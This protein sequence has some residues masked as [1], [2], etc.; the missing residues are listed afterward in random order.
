MC[1]SESRSGSLW[2][3]PRGKIKRSG[4]YW[5]MQVHL[6]NDF[7]VMNVIRLLGYGDEV[8]SAHAGTHQQEPRGFVRLALEVYPLKRRN[9]RHFFVPIKERTLP[10]TVIMIQSSEDWR[11]SFIVSGLPYY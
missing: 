11:L 10:G 5:S 1:I 3:D 4:W 6:I 8:I 7:D 9:P 2:L